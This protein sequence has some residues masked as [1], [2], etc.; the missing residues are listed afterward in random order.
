MF[1]YKIHSAEVAEGDDSRHH[2]LSDFDVGEL[3][4]DAARNIRLADFDPRRKPL[5]LIPPKTPLS[6]A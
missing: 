1:N 2:A 4:R 6:A 3:A 5:F